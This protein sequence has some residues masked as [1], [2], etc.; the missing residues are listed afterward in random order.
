[1]TLETLTRC[2]ICRR[3]IVDV[4]DWRFVTLPD[5]GTGC[6]CERCIEHGDIDTPL[7]YEEDDEMETNREGMPEFNGAFDGR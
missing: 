4:D 5:G 7:T 6:I 1:M 3:S 2:A